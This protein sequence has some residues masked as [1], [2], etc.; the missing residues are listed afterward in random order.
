MQEEK[1]YDRQFLLKL[2][3]NMWMI[4]KFEETAGDCFTKGMVSGNLHICVGQEGLVAGANSALEPSDYITASHRGHGHCLMKSGDAD[5]TMAELFGKADGFCGGRGGSM[6]VSRVESGLL[7]ANGIIGGGIPIATGSA[8]ASSLKG[9]GAVTVAFFGDG[10]ANQGCFHECI[11]MAAAWKLPVIYFIENNGYAVSVPINT[12]TNTADLAERAKGYNIPGIVVDGTDVLEVYEATKQAV[13]RARAGEGP[14]LIDCHVY[15]FIG[16]FVGDPAA[17]I[18][19][20]YKDAAHEQDPIGKFRKYLL[21]H[22]IATVE[23]MDVI[24]QKAAAKIEH[25]KEFAIHAPAPE[26]SAVLDNNY[27]SDNERSVR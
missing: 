4:R 10:A 18:P 26:G 20:S 7:G 22:G 15:K 23:E 12:V 2:L 13:D 9:D 21:D 1:T 14:T 3:E 11:N 25:A 27:S 8:L 19:Q 17:Y 6:H 5:R 16:H 24:E